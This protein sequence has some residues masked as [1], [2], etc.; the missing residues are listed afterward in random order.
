MVKAKIMYFGY[1]FFTLLRLL[2]GSTPLK[3]LS[4]VE[5]SVDPKIAVF[6]LDFSR[7]CVLTPV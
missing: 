4:L 5:N 3:A 7:L 2:R 6:I 1:F